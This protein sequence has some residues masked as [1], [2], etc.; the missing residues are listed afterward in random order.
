MLFDSH[1]H[2]VDEYN[3]TDLKVV[4]KIISDA[5]QKNVDYLIS[6]SINVETNKEN[7]S[8]AEKYNSV[9]LGLGIYPLEFKTKKDLDKLKVLDYFFDL[10]KNIKN[11]TLIGEIGLDFKTSKESEIEIQYM[12]FKKQIKF[13]KENDLF[14]EVHSR[15][16]IK[17]TLKT[18]IEMNAE[19]VIMH[20]YTNSKKYATKAI[21][22]GYFVTI[23][24]SLLYN[25]E[26]VWSVV[27]DLPVEQILFETDYPV[28]F[29]NIIQTPAVIR[30]I[31]EKYALLKE[32]NIKELEKLQ[33]KNFK[34]L[35]PK[36]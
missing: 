5:K 23:G 20:W 19:K 6:N 7:I 1:M 33:K 34:K 14:V 16:A 32:I 25:T 4:D 3:K 30:D 2:L 12:G 29:N 26:Q 36:L 9:C 24:P 8:I 27:K 15:F 35:F 13:A 31:A 22:E 11:K 21:N 17:Q 10:P 28:S 18:L